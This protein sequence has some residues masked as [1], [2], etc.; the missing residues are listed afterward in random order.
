VPEN[1]L[2]DRYLNETIS[3]RFSR[4]SDIVGCHASPARYGAVSLTV[5]YVI[6]IEWDQPVGGSCPMLTDLDRR[7]NPESSTRPIAGDRIHLQQQLVLNNSG[8]D[9]LRIDGPVVAVGC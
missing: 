1:L 9:I 8:G 7:I 5:V 3:I 4:A 6:R 2:I